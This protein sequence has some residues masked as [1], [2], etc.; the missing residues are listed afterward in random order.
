MRS[1][2]AATR[3]TASRAATKRPPRGHL[4]RRQRATAI[5]GCACPVDICHPARPAAGSRRLRNRGAEARPPQRPLGSRP[6]IGRR[7]IPWRLGPRRIDRWIGPGRKAGLAG[8]AGRAGASSA[9]GVPAPGD[10][11]CPA[12][13]VGDATGTSLATLAASGQATAALTLTAEVTAGP[14]TETVWGWLP[15]SGATGENI[16]VNIPHRR[17]ERHRGERRPRPSRPRQVPVGTAPPAQ[18]V[19]RAGDRSLPAAA[20]HRANPEPEERRGGH[21]RDQHVDGQPSRDLRGCD[22]RGN[23][24]AS[25]RHDVDEQRPVAR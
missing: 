22:A 11:G 8:S 2:F 14:A 19:V 20:V 6:Q 18:R 23:S 15:G 17:H 24:G 21:R 4:P 13:W 9:F 3:R 7:L 1:A 25:R 5:W 10:T 16:I 12:V